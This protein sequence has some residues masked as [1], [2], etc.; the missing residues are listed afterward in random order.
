[1][2]ASTVIDMG[3]R[4]EAR[5]NDVRHGTLTLIYVG[6]TLSRTQKCDSYQPL[7]RYFRDHS[8]HN[9]TETMTMLTIL[10]FGRT[11]FDND[12]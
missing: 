9:V 6:S 5:R 12:P 3:D 10:P 4:Y 2:M 8:M 7:K 11:L 1:M